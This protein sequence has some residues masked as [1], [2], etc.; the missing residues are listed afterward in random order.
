MVVAVCIVV[1]ASLLVSFVTIDGPLACVM[2]IL[3]GVLVAEV[4][5][6]AF[7]LVVFS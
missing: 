5:L 7:D 6:S 4:W 2:I 3:A 1:A